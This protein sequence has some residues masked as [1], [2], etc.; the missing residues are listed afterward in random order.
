MSY[1]SEQAKLRGQA[2]PLEIHVQVDGETIARA[3]HNANQANASRAFSP[4]PA[5]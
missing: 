5:Y 2:P 1:A 4:V 3:V